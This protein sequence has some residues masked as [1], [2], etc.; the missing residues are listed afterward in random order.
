MKTVLEE[1]DRSAEVAVRVRNPHK[2]IAQHFRARF[3]ESSRICARR[4]EVNL[5][6]SLPFRKALIPAGSPTLARTVHLSVEERLLPGCT[7]D[8]STLS[9]SPRDVVLRGKD[10]AVRTKSIA[11]QS[12]SGYFEGA[13]RSNMKEMFS[14]EFATNLNF[15]TLSAL[16]FF[17]ESGGVVLH[18]QNIQRLFIAIH[19][20]QVTSLIEPCKE[21]L[22]DK[23]PQT[24]VISMHLASIYEGME[25][26]ERRAVTC[27][28]ENFLALA[29]TLMHLPAHL[30]AMVISQDVLK[31]DS[32]DEVVRAILSWKATR[33][34]S[35]REI[36]HVL[37][38]VRF[39][40]LSPDGFSLVR[41]HFKGASKLT[42][43]Q[44]CIDNN[45]AALTDQ[46]LTRRTHYISH[47]HLIWSET[48]TVPK[49][50]A[51]VQR[52]VMRLKMTCLRCKPGKI[53]SHR[54]LERMP[55]L[56][57]NNHIFQIV[58]VM[59]SLHFVTH[60]RELRDVVVYKQRIDTGRWIL[61]NRIPRVSKVEE[62]GVCV[63]KGKIILSMFAGYTEV[64][65]GIEIDTFQ[66]GNVYKVI[67][68]RH[69]PHMSVSAPQMSFHDDWLIFLSDDRLQLSSPREEDFR[70]L[71]ARNPDSQSAVEV[72]ARFKS[73]V[74]CDKHLYIYKDAVAPS[75]AFR[76][77][78]GL[79]DKVLKVNVDT[80][81]VEEVIAM[82]KPLYK[83]FERISLNEPLLGG[84][85]I[86]KIFVN[87]SKL[88]IALQESAQDF[89]RIV[90]RIDDEDEFSI[91]VDL[92]CTDT[93]YS[94]NRR[95]EQVVPIH[96][97]GC[98]HTTLLSH[99]CS[100]LHDPEQH[101]LLERLQF[102]L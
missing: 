39:P 85:S 22:I 83:T 81:Q 86:R 17:F 7:L 27:C 1:D 62:F 10:G 28:A 2:V 20:F 76:R 75:A 94:S 12:M 80:L 25:D 3:A 33:I 30:M 9:D 8:A 26:L 5:P 92:R 14:G 43:V 47:M 50:S 18:L 98:G 29:P 32:E 69:P 48:T 4:F 77:V 51:P 49:G 11:L 45:F 23:F 63:S 97:F 24:V 35:E 78:Q 19:Y 89:C 73:F 65:R 71:L 52:P 56:R 41:R 84:K 54:L 46:Q 96:L 13:F 102:Y 93:Q 72:L 44:L 82:R 70:E 16:M 101:G 95:L 90:Q 37:Q 58:H 91:L 68:F 55:D 15:A 38:H 34:R 6:E 64:L 67:E 74:R 88:S 42:A 87:G 59:N 31:V 99:F 66:N 100:T 57:N 36:L 61:H 79:F 21:Y 40:H 60:S 53:Q